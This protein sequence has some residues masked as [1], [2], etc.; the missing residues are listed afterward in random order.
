MPYEITTAYD[1]LD[2]EIGFDVH[3]PNGQFWQRFTTEAEAEDCVKQLK[4]EQKAADKAAKARTG[5]TP[6]K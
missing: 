2:N 6:A 5:A 1:G 3:G 4:G